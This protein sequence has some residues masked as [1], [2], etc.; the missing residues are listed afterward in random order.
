METTTINLTWFQLYAIVGAVAV[1]WALLIRWCWR[2]EKRRR[3][4]EAAG[5]EAEQKGEDL[6][7][8]S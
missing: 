5:R 1:L 8:L 7:E 4:E 2:M 3:Q 6:W